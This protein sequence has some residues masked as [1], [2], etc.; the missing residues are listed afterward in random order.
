MEGASDVVK[1][2]TKTTNVAQVRR[3]GF[4]TLVLH[5]LGESHNVAV[6][7][8]RKRQSDGRAPVAWHTFVRLA[9]TTTHDARL[10]RYDNDI[11]G[12]SV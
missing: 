11:G 7:A 10:H 12:S 8:M 6:V 4:E 9:R 3:M 5:I 1:M 2:Y